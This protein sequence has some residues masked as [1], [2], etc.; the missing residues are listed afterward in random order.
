MPLGSIQQWRIVSMGR[1]ACHHKMSMSEYFSVKHGNLRKTS[2]GEKQRSLAMMDMDDESHPFH[3]H[4]NHFQVVHST[5][6]CT[7]D[8]NIGEDYLRL[9][10]YTMAI[11]NVIVVWLSFLFFWV[12]LQVNGEIP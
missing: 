6:S 2:S 10:R 3:L 7:F 8:Y 12:F 1:S 9:K 11:G 4:T 5:S